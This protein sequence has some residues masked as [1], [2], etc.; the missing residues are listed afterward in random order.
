MAYCGPRGIPLSTF[1]GWDQA[2][3]DAALAWQQYEAS[4]CPKCGT[5][6]EEGRRH[7]HVDVCPTCVDLE[8]VSASE[9]AKVRGAHV[10]PAHG[11]RGECPRCLAEV[12]ANAV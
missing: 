2:D 10:S 3:Q 1:L 11:S 4:R 8:K 5:H 12:Q 7:F 9:D 6:P